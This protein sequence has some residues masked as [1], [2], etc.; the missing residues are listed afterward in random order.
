MSFNTFYTLILSA[1]VT[2]MGLLF[3]AVLFNAD[4][5]GHKLG[6]AW[7]SVARSTLNI[8]V[9]LLLLPLVLLFPDSDDQL[10]AAIILM[11]AG[12]SI[13][14]QFVCWRPLR[15]IGSETLMRV[16]PHLLWLFVVPVSAF[17]LIAYSALGFL[18]WNVPF[19]TPRVSLV[20]LGLLMV[21]LRNSW[22][23][24][25]QHGGLTGEN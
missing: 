24:V 15:S 1:A 9:V 4:R 16:R 8:Y 12:F 10:R 7:L 19:R 11:L 18:L 3:F 6:A 5:R 13:V 25:L 23:L 21:A 2:L 14:R 22:N 17:A 20:V